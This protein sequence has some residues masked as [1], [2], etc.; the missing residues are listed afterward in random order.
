V[1]ASLYGIR[2]PDF[3]ALRPAGEWQ[4]YDIWFTRPEFN[5][6]GAL[7]NPATITMKV[8]GVT[9][10]DQAVFTGPTIGRERRPYESHPDAMPLVLQFHGQPVQFRNIWAVRLDEESA[11]IAP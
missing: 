7:V 11:T 6:S 4:Y 5:D 8:N 1:A 10:H 2:P 9:V 3:N